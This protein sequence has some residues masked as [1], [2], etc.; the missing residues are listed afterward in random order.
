M[1]GPR[2]QDEIRT[3][4]AIVDHEI[5]ETLVIE[6]IVFENRLTH[7]RDQLVREVAMKNDKIAE[8]IMK[9]S[10]NRM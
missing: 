2:P 5:I 7:L 6:T 1:K 10:E 4:T 3:M 8:R 9:N